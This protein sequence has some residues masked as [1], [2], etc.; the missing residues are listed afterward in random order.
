MN[1]IDPHEWDLQERARAG[2]G[3]GS[4]GGGAHDPALAAYREVARA[5]R[6]SPGEPPADFA[7]SVAA[8]LPPH[9]GATVEGRLER[10]LLRALAAVLGLACA[11]AIA[12]YGDE[13]FGGLVAGFQAIV[14]ALGGPGAFHWALLA[15]AC[16]ALSWMLSRGAAR[17][18]AGAFGSGG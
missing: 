17:Y 5:L 13:W 2:A 15:G 12:R 6:G 14:P 8:A 18:T 1:R 4:G 9:A 7:A 16:M 11:G 10:W 3:G